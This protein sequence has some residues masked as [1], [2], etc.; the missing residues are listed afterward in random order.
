VLDKAA[1]TKECSRLENIGITVQSGEHPP[2]KWRSIYLYDPDGN[3]VELVCYE[4]ALF[5]LV[6]N[7]KV[8]P[9]I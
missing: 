4:E 2:F 1:F 5:E 8:Q 9:T 6:L 3:C 7:Q